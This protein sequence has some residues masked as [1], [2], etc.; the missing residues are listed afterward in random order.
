MPG[1]RAKQ[2][3]D[4][5]VRRTHAPTT[6]LQTGEYAYPTDRRNPCVSADGGPAAQEPPW[7]RMAGLA[8]TTRID[9]VSAEQLEAIAKLNKVDRAFASAP[10]VA[11]CARP[12]ATHRLTHVKFARSP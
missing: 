9:L 11:A 6:P 4:T 5:R 3:S 8:F 12:A 10:A 1:S 2:V 7:L